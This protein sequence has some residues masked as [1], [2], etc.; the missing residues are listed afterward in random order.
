MT[1]R[2]S[3][4]GCLF[5]LVG[6]A[7]V[8]G[9]AP[10]HYIDDEGVFVAVPARQMADVVLPDPNRTASEVA[11]RR[12]SSRPVRCRLVDYVDCTA[13]ETHEFKDDGASRVRDLPG[14]R[15]RVT[16]PPKGFELKWFQYS[17]R[18]A[19]KAGRPHLLVLE[20]PN[21]R[22]R[23]TTASV[24]MPKDAPWSPPYTGAEKEP[25]DGFS[26]YQSPFWYEPDVGL[27]VYTGRELPIDNKPFR[28]HLIFYP[29]P[30]KVWVTISSSG[31][32]RDK[33]ELDGG[34]VS[35]I[36][37]FEILD[38]LGERAP[39]IDAPAK[40]R[41]RHLG[42]YTT[43]PWYFISH[44]GVPPITKAQRRQSLESLCDL[45]QFCG[46][47]L[48]EFNAVNGS[49][50]AGRAWFPGSFYPQCGTDAHGDMDVSKYPEL[51]VDL[52]S[53]LPEV[54]AQHGI[55]IVPVLTS[56]TIPDRRNLGDTPNAYGF[57]KRSVQM[58]ADPS[59][60]PLVFNQHVPDPLRPETQK[61]LIDRL[62]EIA[63]RS[64]RHSNIVGI[65]FRVNG[66]IGTCYTS[67]E[68]KSSGKTKVVDASQVGYSRWHLQQFR[69]DTKLEVPLESLAAYEWL[70]ADAARW[71]KWLDWR[72]RRMHTFWL[73]ARDAVRRVRYDFK[74]YALTDLPCEVPGTNVLWPGPGAENAAEISLDLLRAHG[75]DPRMFKKD[76][77]III[78]RVMMADQE[79]LF[80]KWGPPWG[81]NPERYRDF[82]E[83]DEVA[84]WYRSPAG[85][86]VEVYHSYW[87]EA[88]HPLGEFGWLPGKGGMRTATGMARGR[89]F[90]RPM[91]F[92][93]RADDCDTMVLNG[94]Q[95][96]VLGHEHDLRR[97]AQAMR[98][99][100]V[101]EPLLV[102]TA[103]AGPGIH[104]AWYGDRL[105]VINDRSEPVRLTITL[106]QPLPAG[107]RLCDVVNGQDFLDSDAAQRSRFQINLLEYEVR[108]L[109]V[110]P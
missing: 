36:W 6:C 44:Y 96:P 87:E 97:F 47:N 81:S 4:L 58:P 93:L 91:S 70:K 22:E 50:R 67:G 110:R 21:D 41:R 78:Q 106:N 100:P 18:T 51:S 54:A 89:A 53:E 92:A 42:I 37:L 7:P 33:H 98:A 80:S 95:R 64:R 2:V 23:Y 29:K 61:W 68:D 17:M 77:G 35:K 13:A 99:L 16:A 40:G 10:V 12:D 84:R 85:A 105:G 83:Q 15:F 88:Y 24:T 104:A 31:W 62:I 20:S 66:K 45:M 79:R 76:E 34:A 107:K 55:D 69:K 48:I 9:E 1:K 63:R 72:C 25:L 109:T 74:L 94:W 59:T 86:A 57:S 38:D 46:L 14:G 101:A 56:L 73:R 27:N 65:G 75:L 19:D 90:Y 8:L 11:A 60:R 108:T 28:W 5:V 3:M 32:Q 43:H 49:D 102:K 71:D 52:L 39:K 103:P 30:A 82:H 26:L